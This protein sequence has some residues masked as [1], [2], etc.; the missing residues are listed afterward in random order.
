MYYNYYIMVYFYYK[1]VVDLFENGIYC[2]L[3]QDYQ[4][5]MLT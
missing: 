3:I 4:Y 5:I 2:K 1:I